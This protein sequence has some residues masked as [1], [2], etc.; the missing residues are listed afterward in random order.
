MR[1]YLDHA[2]SSPLRPLVVEALAQV[3]DMTQ[4]D[5]GRP[6]EEALQIRQLIE[7]ARNSVA[8]LANVT[9]RQVVFGSGIAESTNHAVRILGDGGTILATGAERSSVL[10][11]ARAVGHV[12][13]LSLDH[14]GRL[15]FD[16]LA[17]RL[18]HGDVTLVCTQVANHETGVLG[19]AA[20]VVALAHAAGATVHVDATIGFGRLPLDLTH[21]DADATTVSSELLGGPQGVSALIVKRGAVLAPLLLGGAQERARRAGLENVL[22]IIGFGVAAD[23]LAQPGVLENEAATQRMLLGELEAAAL[24]VPGVQSVG[25]PDPTWRAPWLRCFTITGVEAEGVVMGLDRVGI[26]V[27]SGSACSAESLEPSPVLAAMGIEADR[28][29]RLSTGWSSTQADVERFAAHFG[30]VVARLRALRS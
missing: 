20:R 4:A 26:S 15:D 17:A 18:Q 23:V 10:E 5:P 16:A 29:L 30:E 21:L 14:N 28:S 13:L 11:A 2:S 24:C 22:G 19:E 27:H 3:L 12:E 7:D 25:D 1:S 9:A 6:Y 8:A